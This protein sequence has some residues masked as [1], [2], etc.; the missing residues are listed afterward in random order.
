MC[1][2]VLRCVVLCVSVLS[3]AVQVQ[4]GASAAAVSQ[5]ACVSPLQH[6][7]HRMSTVHGAATSVQC[8]PWPHMSVEMTG[9]EAAPAVTGGLF[10]HPPDPSEFAHLVSKFQST[11]GPRAHGQR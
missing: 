10:P 3:C 8:P 6:C 9:Q 11:A 7:C 5:L 1:C 4:S 2:A